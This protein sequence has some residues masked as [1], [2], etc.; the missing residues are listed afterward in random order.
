KQ[1][2]DIESHHLAEL[3][4]REIEKSAVPGQQRRAQKKQ[5]DTGKAGMAEQRLAHNRIARDFQPGGDHQE[6]QDRQN[7]D[8][9]H[10]ELPASRT[11]DSLK[12]ARRDTQIPPFMATARYAQLN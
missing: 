3:E 8:Q 12:R 9:F 11:E 1:G 4:R 10:G 5:A 7:T 2:G 6:R